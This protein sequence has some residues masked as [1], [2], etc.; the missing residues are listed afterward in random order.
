MEWIY[1]VLI[2]VVL[3][4]GFGVVFI[5]RRRS[6]AQHSIAAQHTPVTGSAPVAVR[7]M[8]SA[9]NLDGALSMPSVHPETCGV[10]STLS[11]S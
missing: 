10:M 8:F 1:L 2:P 5:N 7:P 3:V 11:N 4:F 6:V 9:I